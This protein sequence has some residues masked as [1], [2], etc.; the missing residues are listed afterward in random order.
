MPYL[1]EGVN[2]QTFQHLNLQTG[3]SPNGFKIALLNHHPD[4]GSLRW[5]VDTP[6]DLEFIRQIIARFDNDDFGWHDILDLL[7]KEP[8]LAKINSDVHHKSLME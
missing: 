6:K 2:L 3:T 5:T 1:Y 8:E 4:Y 7:E